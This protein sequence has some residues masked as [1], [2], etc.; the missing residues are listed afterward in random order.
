MNNRQIVNFIQKGV[1]KE[2]K[3]NRRR[4]LGRPW[5]GTPLLATRVYA[6]IRK[7]NYNNIMMHLSGYHPHYKNQGSKIVANYSGTFN[8]SRYIEKQLIISVVKLLNLNFRLLSGYFTTGGT[9]S[10]IYS[11]WIARNWSNS[12]KEECDT[13][14]WI[15]PESSHY[16]I[17]KALN[18]L[19]IVNDQNHTIK[20]VAR[21]EN[22]T[23]E[24]SD[25]TRLIEAKRR[26]SEAPIILVLTIIDT[27]FGFSDPMQEVIDF[28]KKHKYTNI[29]I[30]VDA[31]FSGM[32]LPVVS[33]YQKV[34][35]HEEISTIA[36]DFHKTFGA[37]MGSG[38]VLI[39][40]DYQKFSRV[41]TP[42]LDHADFTLL[43][44]RSGTN[45]IIT[46]ALFI[47]QVQSGIWQ[48]RIEFK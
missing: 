24:A 22:Y 13:V 2:S 1:R 41:D 28:I 18:L 21:H 23:I 7:Y 48:K 29:F 31:C 8:F 35:A 38:M 25:I 46:W 10:N 42:Y 30:H 32:I 37:P 6:L 40:N 17:A 27:E 11:L 39:N 9:E 16:S 5:S 44:S 12:Q 36:I 19:G 20:Y 4:V 43:G 47:R 26:K 14:D 33:G 34:F 15:I 3:I 45:V